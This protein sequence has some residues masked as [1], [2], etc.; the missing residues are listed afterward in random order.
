MLPVICIFIGAGIAQAMNQSRT[1]SAYRAG[2]QD[3]LDTASATAEGARL[4]QGYAL[5]LDPVQAI[6][7]VTDQSLALARVSR[8][9]MAE[10]D[11]RA[12]A[13]PLFTRI[14]GMGA[15]APPAAVA[16]AIV[17]TAASAAQRVGPPVSYVE[18][19]AAQMHPVMRRRWLIAYRDAQ[20]A[21]QWQ[22]VED[23]IGSRRAQKNIQLRAW[24]I[25][26]LAILEG[27]ARA[28]ATR[29]G[30][31]NSAA[32]QTV[33]RLQQYFRAVSGS[34]WPADDDTIHA[35]LMEI[36]QRIAP[37]GT[38]VPRTMRAPEGLQVIRAGRDLG[39]ARAQR[40]EFAERAEARRR[41]RAQQVRRQKRR[42]RA[43]AVGTALL[44]A[45][46]PVAG[47]ALIAA[48]ALA[49]NRKRRRA[50]RAERRERREERRERRADRRAADARRDS[51]L[52]RLITTA[53]PVGAI[54]NAVRNRKRKRAARARARAAMGALLL[55]QSFGGAFV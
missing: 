19:A 7:E 44:T 49:K 54:R 51:G 25:E 47:A 6:A 28:R 9:S 13:L 21:R 2:V 34:S 27:A 22:M 16:R 17:E 45:A 5:T 12:S 8:A 42:R 55:P 24:I 23:K 4:A 3:S 31:N 46:N 26:R 33:E 1:A 15:V 14:S 40:R 32:Q 38:H 53:T 41:R 39:V 29:R 11:R 48:R 50:T 52:V 36:A 37:P 20:P 35:E 30:G 43:G 10:L 18:R